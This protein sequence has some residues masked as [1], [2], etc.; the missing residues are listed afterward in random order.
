M[1]ARSGFD[2]FDG[3]RSRAIQARLREPLHAAVRDTGAELGFV[4][5]G[6]G[7]PS[8]APRMLAASDG[9]A[10]ELLPGEPVHGSMPSA[11]RPAVVDDLW[12]SSELREQEIRMSPAL[13]AGWTLGRGE[14]R[15]VV[16]WRSHPPGDPS[17]RI[18]ALA[19]HSRK[20][21]EAHRLGGLKG[22]Q[23][24]ALDL[25]RAQ[26]RL[27]KA[28]FPGSVTDVHRAIVAV[29]RDLLGVSACYVSVP[30]DDGETFMFAAHRNVRTPTFRSLRLAAG[31]GLGGVARRE[32]GTV[33]ASNYL[34]D[35]RLR[36]APIEETMAEGFRSAL[37]TPLVVDGEVSALLYAA[38]RELTAFTE[39]DVTILEEFAQSAQLALEQAHV[40]RR[41]LIVTR[42]RDREKVASVLH[43]TVLRALTEIGLTAEAALADPGDPSAELQRIRAVAAEAVDAVR[44]SL[45]EVTAGTAGQA[46]ERS[47]GEVLDELAFSG[48]TGRLRRSVRLHEL[49]RE[50]RLDHRLVASLLEIGREALENADRHSGGTHVELTAR[51]DGDELCLSIV[52]DGSA[53]DADTVESALADGVL[54]MGLVRM[55]AAARAAGGALTVG[56]EHGRGARVDV[57]LPLAPVEGEPAA[58]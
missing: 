43:D 33:V 48:G 47:L 8:P 50:L 18:K 34:D 54:H 55:R 58:S 52:D 39:T 24:I 49:S 56:A 15:L 36:G 44:T 38:N 19:R 5:F 9:I 29:A 17:D 57:R 6:R 28:S 12:V 35:E 53:I 37:C 13:S 7:G 10:G 4:L 32:Q 25:A 11:K 2:V 20:L 1:E 21:R 14:G 16:G 45:D 27:R 22:A 40:D 23:R 30:S 31:E 3:G 41:R 51:G 46:R 26:L 42:T